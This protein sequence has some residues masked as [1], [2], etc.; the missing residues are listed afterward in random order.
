MLDSD[1]GTA[2]QIRIRIK[3]GHF[4][5]YGSGTARLG[6]TKEGAK[7]STGTQKATETDKI[8]RSQGKTNQPISSVKLRTATKKGLWY[9]ANECVDSS[10]N[11]CMVI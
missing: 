4:N 5:T 10:L 9:I 6:D 7:Q 3:G 1:T 11:E 8:K 2:C